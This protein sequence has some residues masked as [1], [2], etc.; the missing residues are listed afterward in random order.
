M[1]YNVSDGLSDVGHVEYLRYRM[2]GM[3]HVGNVGCWRCGVLGIWDIGDIG[4]WGCG[5][6]GCGILFGMF[7]MGFLL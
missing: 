4:C 2:L 3:W 5:M 1:S 7:D 6:L